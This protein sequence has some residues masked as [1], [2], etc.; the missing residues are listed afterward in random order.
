MLSVLKML[1]FV[2]RYPGTLYFGKDR[3]VW[4][5][6]CSIVCCEDTKTLFARSALV[7]VAIVE[8]SGSTRLVFRRCRAVSCMHKPLFALCG[9]SAGMH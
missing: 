3:V 8:A 7:G 9:K 5:V 4:I 1:L 2:Q 6:Y